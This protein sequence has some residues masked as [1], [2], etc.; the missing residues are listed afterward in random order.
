MSVIIKDVKVT[1][2]QLGVNVPG[3]KR[4]VV[5]IPSCTISYV[6]KDKNDC[7]TGIGELFGRFRK[8]DYLGKA[9]CGEFFVL[10]FK[11]EWEFIS[12][13]G[14]LLKSM[15]PCGKIIGVEENNIVVRNG[16]IITGYDREGQDIGSRKLTVEEMKML[17][18]AEMR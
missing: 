3:K 9:V 18:E 11:L 6:D 12:A 14:K 2:S 15:P 16:D 7:R 5:Y 8:S 1:M 10:I 4:S 17:D 13:D